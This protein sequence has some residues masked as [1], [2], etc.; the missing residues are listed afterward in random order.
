MCWL[1]PEHSCMIAPDPAR[2]GHSTR[3]ADAMV[4]MLDV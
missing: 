4:H 2:W 1:R 3:A